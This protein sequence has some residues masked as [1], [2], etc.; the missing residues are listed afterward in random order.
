[1]SPSPPPSLVCLGISA[2]E[3]DTGI[4]KDTLR[5]W[6]RRY[7]FP[8]PSRDPQ[9]ERLYPLDQVEQLRHIRRL[10]DA[11]LR[12][13]KIVGLSLAEL[14]ALSARSMPAAPSVE[15]AGVS[16]AAPADLAGFMALVRSHDAALL[17]KRC[18]QV[19]MQQGLGR[20]VLHT[21]MPL[22]NAVGQAWAQGELAVYEEH[23]CSEALETVLRAAMSSIGDGGAQHTGPKVLLATLPTEL[24]GLGLL[25]AQ[26]MFMMQGCPCLSLGTQLPLA[27]L[28][29]AAGAHGSDIVALSFS[30]AHPVQQVLDGLTELRRLLPV[31]CEI[32]A[33]C[34]TAAVKRRGAP[35]VL[36][37]DR[38]EDI[39]L[40]VQHWRAQ[41]GT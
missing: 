6:E 14:A 40:A 8:R 3:R 22:C 26:A 41:R 16:G 33:G 18:A 9:G 20:F 1:M 23:L 27:D 34:P 25:M 2:V 28:A 10:M 38:M 36:V 37:F 15:A 32:W 31:A 29:R 12:P 4:G 30:A 17:S 35:G 21:A 5:V 7:G 39:E 19:V 13:G 24:H 11:G